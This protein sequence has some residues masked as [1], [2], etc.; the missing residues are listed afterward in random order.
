MGEGADLE[1]DLPHHPT[2]QCEDPPKDLSKNS[3]TGALGEP[4]F[5][6]RGSKSGQ[7]RSDIQQR[8]TC[9]KGQ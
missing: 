4:A 8:E 6:H 2:Q 9:Y 5:G 7:K 3:Y 1:P